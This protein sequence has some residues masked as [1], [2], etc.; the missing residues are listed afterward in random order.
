MRDHPAHGAVM[1]GGTWAAKVSDTRNRFKK[2][3]SE[4][5]KNGLAYIDRFSGGWDQVALHRYKHESLY[6]FVFNLRFMWTLSCLL[7]TFDYTIK[8]EPTT[9]MSGRGLRRWL[10]FTTHTLA[11]SF[12]TPTLF[13]LKGSLAL[14]IMLVSFGFCSKLLQTNLTS[15][16]SGSVLALNASIDEPCP[17]KCRPKNHKDWILC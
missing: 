5:F 14:A 10:L 15:T 3:F 2:S 16:F 11:R 8:S 4:L 13:P 12:P 6:L 17:E 9:G 1:M 7:F